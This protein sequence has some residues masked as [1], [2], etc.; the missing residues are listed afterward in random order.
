ML[1]KLLAKEQK[2][3]VARLTEMTRERHAKYGDTLFHLEPNIK[4]CP[5]GLRDV[6]V[7]GWMAKVGGGGARGS[8]TGRERRAAASRGG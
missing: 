5:G 1:P 7:C 8:E 3:I 4:D 6:H 2:A